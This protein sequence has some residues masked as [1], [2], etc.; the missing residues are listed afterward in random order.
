MVQK[1]HIGANRLLCQRSGDQLHAQDR[2]L[3]PALYVLG[4]VL[5]AVIL[6]TSPA[7]CVTG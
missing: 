6:P 7:K 1:P 4:P 5:E 3:P 2:A